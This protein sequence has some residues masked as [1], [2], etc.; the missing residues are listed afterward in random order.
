MIVT[1]NK[2]EPQ[3]VNS[4]TASSHAT[5]AHCSVCSQVPTGRVQTAH[6]LQTTEASLCHGHS[7]LIT[8]LWF[9]SAVALT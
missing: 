9:G 4:D 1:P 2:E 5:S 7:E 3:S 6:L 8:D